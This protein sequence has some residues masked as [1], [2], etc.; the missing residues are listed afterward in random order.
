MANH[1]FSEPIWGGQNPRSPT[2][3]YFQD[4]AGS[5]RHTERMQR[6]HAIRMGQLYELPVLPNP[7][8]EAAQ[9]AAE[10]ERAEE[11]NRRSTLSSAVVSGVLGA[12]SCMRSETGAAMT[13]QY[14]AN[15]DQFPGDLGQTA[16][17]IGTPS[18][19]PQN[20]AGEPN[21]PVRDASQGSAPS[22]PENRA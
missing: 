13:H 16:Q 12:A 5:G 10:I 20:G 19:Q 3:G 4:R 1:H 7:I 15:Y 17:S 18:Q 22:G 6:S 14:A 8:H 9:F 11:L 21:A 2:T